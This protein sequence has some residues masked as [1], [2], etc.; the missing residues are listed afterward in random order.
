MSNDTNASW[1]ASPQDVTAEPSVGLPRIAQRPKDSP[2]ERVAR[3]KA[4]RKTAPRSTHTGWEAHPGRPDPV[5]LLEKQ[6]AQRAPDLVPIRYGRMLSSPFAFYRGGAFIMASDLSTT[7]VSGL[8][9]QLCG[10]AHPANF[11][12]FESAERRLIFDINDFDETLHGPWEWDVKRL[13]AG[14]AIAARERGFSAALSRSIVKACVRHYRETMAQMAEG[15]AI[16]AW[17]ARLDA[18]MIRQAAEDLKVIP[19]K[20]VDKAIA[21]AQSKDSLR[22][23]SKLTECVDGVP[24]FRNIPP[25]LVPASDLLQGDQRQ[26]YSASVE[27]ALRNYRESL[28]PARR[29][30]FDAYRFREIARKVVGVGSVGTRAWAMLFFGR[31]ESDPL[32][33]QAKQAER[34]V[35]EPF[36]GPS[37]YHHSGRRVVEGQRLMQAASDILLG[38]YRVTGFDGNRYDFYVRQ[39]WDGKGAFDLERLEAPGWSVYAQMCAWTLARAHARTG[40]RIAIAAYLGSS[41][42]FDNSVAEFAEAYA[43]QN[44]A[45]FEA[46]KAAE[47]SGR[48]SAVH[49]V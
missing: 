25:L 11:G 16:D 42:T 32:L 7:P 49:G 40:D 8:T 13:A 29:E 9:A 1:S 26:R 12:L 21:K 43:E 2:A 35:L 15:R 48:I 6:A 30:L 41:D 45:D 5:T 23:L 19:L 24:R 27:E 31:D 10:D 17:Y 44:R 46:L 33:L 47:A 38:W 34:S 14:F 39:L 22:A 20:R 36:V 4:A 18:E 3:G 37:R 28:P